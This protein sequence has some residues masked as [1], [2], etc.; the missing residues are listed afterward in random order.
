MIKLSLCTGV[1]IALS[2]CGMRSV[3]TPAI[4]AT[5][6][7][8]DYVDLQAGWRLRVVIPLLKSGGRLPTI[9]EHQS[10]GNVVSLNTRGDFIGYEIAYYAVRPQRQAGV[11]IQF[12]S[13]AVTKDGN[14]VPEA[15]APPNLSVPPRRMKYARLLYLQ[16]V[17]QI[18]HDMALIAARHKEVLN[19][20]T[21]QVQADPAA[22]RSDDRVFCTWIP[23]G[24]AV[25]PEKQRSADD[26]GP[27]IPAH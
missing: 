11:W 16:R 3:P 26:A 10:A 6:P 15:Q 20:S 8:N 1:L 23:K 27:W 2:G 21:R 22:C 4:P 7:S 13:A 18:D 14:T 12:R 5:F 17:S 9:T 25:R 19:A 24:T